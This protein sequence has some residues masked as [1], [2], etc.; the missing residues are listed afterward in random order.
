[1]A[2]A[3]GQRLAGGSILPP[4]GGS[5]YEPALALLPAAPEDMQAF[6]RKLRRRL[7]PGFALVSR[8][9]RLQQ[10]FLELKQSAPSKTPLDALLDICALHWDCEVT[11]NDKGEVQ[12]TWQR[13]ERRGWLVPVPMG[14]A[15]ISPLYDAGTVR[16]A[17]DPGVPFRFV[18]SVYGLSEWISP[19]RVDDPRR[20]LW[21]HQADPSRGLYRCINNC[22]EA[23]SSIT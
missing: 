5:A 18:E 4:P 19:H 2:Q 21:H 13:R 10:R 1:L 14:Y 15:A 12:A 16:N 3:Q 7:L 22:F 11:D 9:D 6:Y 17:R 20:L 8:N 23:A